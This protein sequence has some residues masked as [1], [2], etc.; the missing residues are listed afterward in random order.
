AY[1]YIRGRG[2][3][4]PPPGDRP[5]DLLWGALFTAGLLASEIP[6][7]WLQKRARLQ[8]LAAVRLGMVVMTLAGL[9][10]VAVRAIELTH[11]NVR[12]GDDAYASLVWM[13]IVLHTTHVVTDLA[14]TFV[15]GTWLFTHEPKTSQF[16][17]VNDNCAYWSFVVATWLPIG[18]LVYLGPRLL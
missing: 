18:F 11:I 1:L 15:L 3:H 13:L 8:D 5:P 9:A 7:R 16:S 12:W 2:G 10:L 14:D 17:D 6:N 4:W